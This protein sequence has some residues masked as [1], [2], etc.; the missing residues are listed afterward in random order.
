[1]SPFCGDM[2]KLEP[3]LNMLFTKLLVRT[4]CPVVVVVVVVFVV[5]FVHGGI[6]MRLIIKIYIGSFSAGSI[7]RHGASFSLSLLHGNIVGHIHVTCWSSKSAF[8]P[9]PQPAEDS[10]SAL[11][12]IIRLSH[13]FWVFWTNNL[14]FLAPSYL[15]L[16]YIYLTIPVKSFFQLTNHDCFCLYRSSCLCHQKKWRMGRT[17]Q[18]RNP[19]CSSATWSVSSSASTSWARSC[20]TS[21]STKWMLSN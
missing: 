21:S 15:S 16:F 10:F 13:L 4:D 3:N 11:E 2:D 7:S 5:V 20:L 1:M 8:Y 9:G 19:N 6:Q 18:M 14:S 17:L 12:F